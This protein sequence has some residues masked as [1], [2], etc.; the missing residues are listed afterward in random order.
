MELHPHFRL[1]GKA[2]T[3][4]SLWTAAM[5]WSKD[6]KAPQKQLGLFLMDWLSE[7]KTIVLY[8][9][10][11]TG[12][13]KTIEVPKTSMVASAHRTGSYF[14]LLAKDSALL[15]LP[16]Q[17][18][19]GKMMLVRA[20][21]L[22]LDLDILPSKTTLNLKGKA[23]V[24]TALI[25]LQ[26]QANFDQLHHFKTILIG[27]APIAD[28]LHKSLA[29]THPNCFE[30][31]GMT[32]T[33][34]HVATRQVSYPPTPFTAMPDVTFTLDNDNCLLL[35]VPYISNKSIATNDIVEHV[36]ENSFY[37]LGRRDFVINSGGKKI[38]PELLEQQLKRHLKIPFFFIGLPDKKLGEKLALII[39]G[40]EQDKVQ[41]LEISI[42]VLG[43]DKHHIPKAVFCVDAFEYTFSGKLDRKA[44]I[45]KVVS[46][47]SYD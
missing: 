15:C 30:T 42:N 32:E 45:R 29:K 6:S 23:Y 40:N 27:G 11:S 4:K 25:P 13:P 19:A 36:D 3:N 14:G 5:G 20:M 38:F 28:E 35:N 10:G 24:F 16:V 26:A 41:A 21:V 34:T 9:S 7:R 47:I 31:Y 1:N 17:Y 43:N 39:K 22:G 2:Y 12:I 33:L 8:S 44:T 37:L 18:I 46:K